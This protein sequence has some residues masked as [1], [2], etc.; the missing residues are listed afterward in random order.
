[1][2]N[3]LKHISMF[4]ICIFDKK[5]ANNLPAPLYLHVQAR[6][7]KSQEYFALQN[8]EETHQGDIHQ[9]KLELL[10]AVANPCYPKNSF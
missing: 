8:R 5:K 6:N 4:K 3:K 10:T 1:M 2:S 9:L 7:P